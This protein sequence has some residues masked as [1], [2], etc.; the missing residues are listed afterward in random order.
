MK[1]VLAFLI[2]LC[3]MAAIMPLGISADSTPLALSY[4]DYYTFEGA[5]S[6][7]SSDTS[8]LS[9]SGNTVHA[10]GLAS[11][12]VTV[13]ADGEEYS[14]TVKKAKIN[15]V[16]V[17]GQS[18]ACGEIS[19][20]PTES[21]FYRSAT[22]TKG[23]AYLWGIGATKPA[24]L[25][26]NGTYDG[27][28][29]ALAEE[30]Y[31]QSLLAG[32]PEKTVVVFGSNHTG[33]PGEKIAEFLD[34]S[35]TKGTV[36]KA[37]AMLNAC[38]EYYSTGAG[39]QFYDITN[40]GMY[41]LQGESDSTQSVTYYY[42]NFTTLWKN[43][44]TA[45]Q[46][47]LNYCAFMRVR[48]DSGTQNL[49]YSG[50][51]IAQYQLTNDNAD[52]FMASTI[53]E[54][55][56]G[57]TTDTVRI[58]VSK[59]H[60]FDEDQ[61][62][63]V[64]SADGKTITAQL[65]HVYGGLHYTRMGY[66]IIGA[67]AGY[68]MY[69]SLHNPQTKLV[70]TDS[71]G[72]PGT[73]LDV[74]GAASFKEEEITANLYA[75]AAPGS[76]PTTV[77]TTINSTGVGASDI[78]ETAINV[79]SAGTKTGCLINIDK[80]FLYVDPVITVTA[81]AGKADFQIDTATEDNPEPFGESP[82]NAVYY[83]WDFTDSSTY[84][85]GLNDGT[86]SS[87]KAL[88]VRT[89]P[90]SEA[91]GLMKYSSSANLNVTYSD[92]L[93]IVRSAIT[94][95]YFSIYNKD[96]GE[97]ITTTLTNGF[98]I[99]FT[100]AFNNAAG[101]ILGK[102]NGGSGH[103]F[104]FKHNNST[105]SIGGSTPSGTANLKG[106]DTTKPATYRFTFDGE[107]YNF[108]IFQDG[109]LIYDAPVTFNGAVTES[110]FNW[111]F[112]L[113]CF[114]SNS[115][116]N[117]AGSVSDV[118]FWTSYSYA[119]SFEG[120]S[121]ATYTLNGIGGNKITAEETKFTVTPSGI[122]LIESVSAN[123]EKL[124]PDQNGYYTINAREDTVIRI[125]T[126][127]NIDGHHVDEGVIVKEPTCEEDG[128]KIYT[129]LDEGCGATFEELIAALGHDI[130]DGVITKE[131]TKYSAGEKRYSCKNA[132]C[133][134][135]TIE[136]ISALEAL[137]YHWDFTNLSTYKNGSALT[138]NTAPDSQAVG[139]LVYVSGAQSELTYSSGGLARENES[140]NYFT[141]INKDGTTG[142]TL[143]LTDGYMM[144]FTASFPTNNDIIFGR[145]N[146]GHGHPFIFRNQKTRLTI[147][148]GTPSGNITPTG[149]DF[150]KLATYL[151]TFDGTTYHAKIT[152]GSTV[153]ET[154]FTFTADVAETW[155]NINYMFPNFRSGFNYTGT[156]TDVK[157]W[158][159]YSFD[160][161]ANGENFTSSINSG[162]LVFGD[163][164]YNFTLT[165]NDGYEIANVTSS[166]GL[167][168][169]NADGSYTLSNPT[170]DAIIT[171]TTQKPTLYGDA[172]GD[173]KVDLVDLVRIKKYLAFGEVELDLTAAN[174]DRDSKGAI[175]ANDLTVIINHILGKPQE[176]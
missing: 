72:L 167:L 162:D 47:R 11:A 8:V 93:G 129:C 69:R 156:V 80:L 28:R 23:T 6:V 41:W 86:V 42:E 91:F 127:A 135:H 20:T 172:N 81:S 38:Y 169:K 120:S 144:E 132:G 137:Y 77:K 71:N 40:C 49:S 87:E 151:I 9:V 115:G 121:A 139:Q 57:E 55:W 141:I 43:L 62:A 76:A 103:P 56:T 94:N 114:A 148:G 70:L 163:G 15:I 108:K 171:V 58:D 112:F 166:T 159:S 109:A 75:Y 105:F 154:D 12:P 89:A 10:V 36:G 145:L 54:N 113:P 30:W 85:K 96:G 64:I 100:G 152:Q 82:E 150:T 170:A 99:E 138:I 7:T 29:A 161:T 34:E 39:A 173:G 104:F 27:F 67:D 25:S 4:D 140:E 84:S 174:A 68:N 14:V 37:S 35:S 1:K 102:K 83:H 117:F 18:N 48:R 22:T 122:Y 95:D 19:G 118:K 160:V 130:D 33:T 107:N 133:D 24:A 175:D 52:M 142:V 79:M 31:Q 92:S 66:N 125:V 63:S 136:Y 17:A 60:V 157:F 90:D 131:P 146:A 73:A 21:N 61:Y 74:G 106:I 59:Y 5:A 149:I 168:T 165:P 26:G 147:G 158:T 116:Y 153:Y 119:L 51:V 78:T 176:I 46:N 65:T 123:G 126:A 97:G 13:T 155:L 88:I 3:L 110:F 50:P 2:C 111:N 128:L 124:T 98:A 16:M 45:T 164:A 44:K 101:I 53:T 143:S 32:D 134:E